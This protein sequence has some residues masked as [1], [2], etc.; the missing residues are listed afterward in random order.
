[1]VVAQEIAV[2]AVVVVTVPVVVIAAVVIAVTWVVVRVNSSV[3]IVVHVWLIQPSVPSAMRW[4]ML[5]KPCASWQLKPMA[6]R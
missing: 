2:M 5:R 4:N 1:M 6:K 3:K